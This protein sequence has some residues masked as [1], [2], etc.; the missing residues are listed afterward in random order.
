M[1][2]HSMYI[3]GI[4]SCYD[5][6][7]FLPNFGTY[8]LYMV[9][10]TEC[11]SSWQQDLWHWLCSIFCCLVR[12]VGWNLLCPDFY[13]IGVVQTYSMLFI[14]CHLYIVLRLFCSF[15]TS[16][17]FLMARSTRVSSTKG[18]DMATCIVFYVPY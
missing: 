9:S 10:E 14:C 4:E 18:W 12:S 6:P 13:H 3:S 1:C 15:L 7:T 8:C 11:H 17:S 16:S 5:P 2:G